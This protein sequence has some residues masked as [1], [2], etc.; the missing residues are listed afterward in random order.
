MRAPFRSKERGIILALL[1]LFVSAVVFTMWHLTH[2]QSRLNESS[3]LEH[4]KLYAEVIKEFRTL[5]T[6]EVVETV[7]NQG[8]MV[9]HDYRDHQGA[10]PLPATL[11]M[12]LGMRIGKLGSGAQT[13]LYSAYPF[14]WRKEKN[15][16]LFQ[17]PFVRDAWEY[18][19]KNSD[20]DEPFYRFEEFEGRVSLRYAMA[21]RMRSSCVDCHNS[22][23][24][25]PK[26]DW[27]VNDVRG[28]LEIITPMDLIIEH[29]RAGLR[30]TFRL[31]GAM[32]MLGGIGL[33]LV[34]ARF[35]RI[36]RRDI[37]QQRAIEEQ[38]RLWQQELAH[39]SRVSTMG[40]L[41]ASLAH[42]LSQPLTAIVTNAQAIKRMLHSSSPD[43]QEVEEALTDITQDGKRAG[44][45][46]AGLRVM[47]K[48][49]APEHV[50]L[51]LNQ[52][53]REI[54]RFLRRD[55][56][57]RDLDIEL[58]LASQLPAVQGN[59]TQLQQVILN[60]VLN[61]SEAMRQAGAVPEPVLIQT[62]LDSQGSVLVSVR[63]RASG[64]GRDELERIF[65]PFYTTKPGGMGMGLSINRT[66]LEA[67]GGRI[68]A[69]NN[70]DGPGCTFCF[71]L[72]D[73]VSL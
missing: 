1:V 29:T 9:T 59:R 69:E 45:V 48:K 52:A 21:D 25:T 4:A 62:L 27:N 19:Q 23:P 39:V 16:R 50:S 14:P 47:L 36:A 63:D 72:P 66:I 53:I 51:D 26:N 71:T 2:L 49:E 46:I 70:A 12:L 55:S 13:R 41:T 67:H 56:V 54:V 20:S 32:M 15:Q 64:V 7:R 30:D 58:E 5:Y 34:I 6:Q 68:W 38:T 60:L 22:H 57:L 11:S 31:M 8:I 42:D 43:G 73:P 10:I 3:A 37:R 44:Q 24:E 61:A 35:R 33:M 28:V 18:W 65:D 40:E 17:D